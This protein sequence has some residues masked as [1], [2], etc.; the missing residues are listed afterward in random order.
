MAVAASSMDP[1]AATIGNR[2]E[3]LDVN[4][5][6]LAREITLIPLRRCGVGGAVSAIETTQPGPG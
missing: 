2:C 1:P 4:V 3:L 5:D 6:Q